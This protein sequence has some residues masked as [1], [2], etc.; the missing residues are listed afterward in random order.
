MSILPSCRIESLHQSGRSPGTCTAA[1]HPRRRKPTSMDSYKA[2]I[3]S[4]C[5][6]VEWR[7]SISGEDHQERA[8]AQLRSVYEVQGLRTA[9]SENCGAR[10]VASEDHARSVL[11]CQLF[12]ESGGKVR[13]NWRLFSSAGQTLPHSSPDVVGRTADKGGSSASGISGGGEDQ[14]HVRSRTW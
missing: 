2:T 7:V 10:A 8:N 14:M 13:R 4:S 1:G 12:R 6:P 5:H 9:S 3:L 11:S